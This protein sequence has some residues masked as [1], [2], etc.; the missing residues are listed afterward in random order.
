M[1]WRG[2]INKFQTTAL[3]APF[4]LVLILRLEADEDEAVR[5]HHLGL[6]VV[7]AGREFPWQQ[8]PLAF[9]EPEAP[10]PHS[11][12][13]LLATLNLVLDRPG[14]GRIE[15]VIDQEEIIPGLPFTVELIP[16]PPG[17]PQAPP[18]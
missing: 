6:R 18:Q 9:K 2:G 8:S 15:L 17:F 7:H 5:L 10:D 4:R 13:N 12:L 3:P 16:F 1:V 11:Y 14:I